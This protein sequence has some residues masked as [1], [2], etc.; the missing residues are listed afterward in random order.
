MLKISDRLSIPENELEWTAVRAQGPG[1]QNVNK[2]SSAVHLRFDIS[3]SAALDD[4][5]KERLLQFSDRRIS[6]S[7]VV[8][9]KSQRYRRQERNREDALERLRCLLLKGL[10]RPTPRK[11]TRPSRKARDKRLED[12]TRRSKLKESR[13]KLID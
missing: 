11:A 6:R 13:R 4:E 12:K 9:I 7:G 5:S 2:V 3:K 10:T 8:V 1:G